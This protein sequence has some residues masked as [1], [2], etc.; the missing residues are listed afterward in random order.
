MQEQQMVHR[1]L[2]LT[3]AVEEQVPLLVHRPRI[4]LVPAVVVVMAVLQ[5]RVALEPLQGMMA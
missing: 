1:G 3:Q 5:V 4:L 2:Q